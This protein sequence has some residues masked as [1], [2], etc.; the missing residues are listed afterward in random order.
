MWQ[1]RLLNYIRRVA[2][3]LSAGCSFSRKMDI[4]G[5]SNPYLW[6]NWLTEWVIKAVLRSR[7]YH[8]ESRRVFNRIGE[9]IRLL[10]TQ[11][12]ALMQFSIWEKNNGNSG[13]GMLARLVSRR[14]P[15]YC[16]REAFSSRKRDLLEKLWLSMTLWNVFSK[17]FTTIKFVSLYPSKV[18]NASPVG[19][20]SMVDE[21]CLLSTAQKG[22]LCRCQ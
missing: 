12:N 11:C 10:A 3:F 7:T 21:N 13:P 1:W 20:R 19:F 14:H 17:I 15:H 5:Y 9:I 8:L 4:L 2:S 18:S 22:T 6:P 16:P